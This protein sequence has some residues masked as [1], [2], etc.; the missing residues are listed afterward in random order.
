L[1]VTDDETQECYAEIV[2]FVVDG[3]YQS[4]NRDQFLAGALGSVIITHETLGGSES[5]RDKI[6][7]I[8]D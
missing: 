3:D 1:A 7:N 8:C 6:P 5:K 4:A 2:Q